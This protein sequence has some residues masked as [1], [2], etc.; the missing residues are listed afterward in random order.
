MMAGST[1]RQDPLRRNVPAAED[2]AMAA[3]VPAI[4]S[5]FYRFKTNIL[6]NF[7]G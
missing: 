7:V 4:R 6:P 2:A 3:H 5:P 1:F